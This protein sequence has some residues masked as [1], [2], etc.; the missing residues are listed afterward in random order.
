M[1]L[2]PLAVTEACWEIMAGGA[3]YEWG[4]A[5]LN[6]AVRR[7]GPAMRFPL[8]PSPQRLDHF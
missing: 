5:G 1:N 6:A 7:P 4:L 8:A 2:E 3:L